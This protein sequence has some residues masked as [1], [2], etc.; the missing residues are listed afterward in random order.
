MVLLS[1]DLI[2]LLIFVPVLDAEDSIV[3]YHTI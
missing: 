1:Q 3:A 2:F